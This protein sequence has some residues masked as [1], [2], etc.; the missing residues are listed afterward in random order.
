[1]R[2]RRSSRSRPS[3]SIAFALG[4]DL[5]LDD[6]AVG[7]EHEIAVAAG[8]AV[9]LIIEVEHRGAVVD[10]AA[11]RRDLGADRVGLDRLGGEQFVDRDAQRD[12]GAR[13]RRGA[14]AAVGLDDVAIDDDLALAERFQVD[15]GAQRAPDQPLDFLGP[16]RLLAL[17]RLAVAAGVGG[18]REHAIF[19]GDPA[20]AL[21]AQ[22]RRELVLDRGGDQHARVAEADQAG[23]FGMAGEAGLE[24]KLAHLVGG[25]SGRAHTGMSP[26]TGAGV[27]L[28]RDRRAIL[29][30]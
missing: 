27:S 28:D 23:A 30:A 15:H 10:S 19:G 4:G 21:A 8:L 1:M 24:A 14:G 25:A 16:A 3:S 9:L 11:D 29:D 12:P 17:G 7:G 6:R 18:A 13:D 5:R 20:L 22:E 26:D 2:A